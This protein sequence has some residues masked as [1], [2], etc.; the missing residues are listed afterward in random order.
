M[1]VVGTG[2]RTG[3]ALGTESGPA[4]LLGSRVLIS[5]LWPTHCN[6]HGNSAKLWGSQF[7]YL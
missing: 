7:S 4:L 2:C 6:A 5:D 3:L 1:E